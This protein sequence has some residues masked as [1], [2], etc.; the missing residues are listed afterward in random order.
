MNMNW[1]ES[2][3]YGFVSGISE[4]LPISSKA[5]QELCMFMFGVSKTDPVRDFVVHI[6][7]IIALL[8]GC[9]PIFQKTGRMP[10]TAYQHVTR[11][12]ID[13]RFVK[14]ATAPML[15]SLIV[16]FYTTGGFS[17]NLL[18]CSGM[19]LVN[20]ILLYAPSRMLQGNKDARLMSQLDSITFGL[21]GGLGAITGISRIGCQTGLAVARGA[22]RQHAL[23]WALSLCMPALIALSFL[24]I[25]LMFS[26]G[27]IPFWSSFFTYL[28][29]AAGSFLG[30]FCAIR[31]AQIV[32]TRVGF[33]GFAYYSWGA[34]LLT[35]LLYLFAV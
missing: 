17:K 31:L 30:G 9:A 3:V 27:S 23:N 28:L 19:L 25:L 26:I 5:H 14:G 6:A 4:F 22:D 8:Y 33:Y 1:F 10:R 7:M 21:I 32:M 15:I 2:I 11:Q 18:V 20:G 24:D 29:S 13:R 16:L 35:F 34:S 12:Q